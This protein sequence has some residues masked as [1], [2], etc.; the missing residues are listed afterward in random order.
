MSLSRSANW[1]SYCGGGLGNIEVKNT[2]RE[3]K[4]V[5]FSS[6]SLLSSL[7]T[8]SR[9]MRGVNCSLQVSSGLKNV[10][11]CISI[12]RGMLWIKSLNLNGSNKVWK[13]PIYL[14]TFSWSCLSSNLKSP[15]FLANLLDLLAK[16]LMS[17]F[18]AAFESVFWNATTLHRGRVDK[19]NPA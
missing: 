14:Q 11:I 19:N 16:T 9:P 12:I 3:S 15:N 17:W 18:C 10:Q 4:S 8:S 1:L 7:S 13:Q 2:C 6:N 5:M